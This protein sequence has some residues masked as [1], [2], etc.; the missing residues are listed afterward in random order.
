[1]QQEKS[2]IVSHTRGGYHIK[3]S[4]CN[5]MFPAVLNFNIIFLVV[6]FELERDSNKNQDLVSH[7]NGGYH[8]DRSGCHFICVPA[9]L[10]L[11]SCFWL[12]VLNLRLT[13][14]YHFSQ[15]YAWK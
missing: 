10:N 3:G 7:T 13:Q 15:L 8:I 14:P 2:D 12:P 5:F 1:M 11:I 6:S 9:V 4:G